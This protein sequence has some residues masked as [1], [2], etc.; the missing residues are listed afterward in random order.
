MRRGGLSVG[1]FHVVLLVAVLA[2]STARSAGDASSGS[3]GD[4]AGANAA[5]P[6]KKAAEPQAPVKISADAAE[7]SNTEGLVVFTG[8]VVAVQADTTLS[9]ERMEVSFDKTAP[10]QEKEKPATGIGAPANAQRI[11]RIVAEKK[12][13]FRQV[14]PESGKERY[15]TGEKGVYDVDQRLVTISGNPRLWEGKNVI[16]G[17]EMTFNLDDKKVIVKGKVNLTVFPDELKEGK[18]P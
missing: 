9:A 6:V 1:L 12:V 16:V 11:A 4:S 5:A 7:Y 2:A 15:A 8:N 17:D 13:S 10:A 14:D 18:K 3:P